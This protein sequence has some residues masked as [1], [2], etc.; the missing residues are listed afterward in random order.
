MPRNTK[1]CIV[2]D[3]DKQGIKKGCCK[4]HC[5]EWEKTGEIRTKEGEVIKYDELQVIRGMI[6]H[7]GVNVRTK[8]DGLKLTK[9]NYIKVSNKSSF[10]SVERCEEPPY[11]R[12]YTKIYDDEFIS[13][14]TENCF[15]NFDLNMKNF[16]SLNKEDFH[17]EINDFLLDNE[18][19]VEVT[20]L[21]DFENVTGYYMMVLDEYK[22]VYIGQSKNI[23]KRI[24]A[25][26]SN[27]KE[28]DRL[29]FG[30]KDNSMLSIDSFRALDTTR[31]FAYKTYSIYNFEDNF[32]NFFHPKFIINR[33]VGG[34]LS[35]L[36]E[37]IANAKTRELTS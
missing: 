30:N 3:C 18:V 25:H 9:E 22:Q 19:F 26:W 15:Y 17:V 20:N 8:S 21:N 13:R 24:M 11:F 14:H 10:P 2:E 33:T 16:S 28:F 36:G 37:A 29:I 12:R 34:Q 32:I 31:I 7:F 1:V 5:T 35:G 23:K 4:S 27:Q 6:E